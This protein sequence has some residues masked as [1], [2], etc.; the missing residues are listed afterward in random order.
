MEDEYNYDVYEATDVDCSADEFLTPTIIPIQAA[1]RQDSD[2]GAVLVQ[3]KNHSM[4]DG[5]LANEQANLATGDRI[6]KI[7]PRH[8]PT[9]ISWT[10]SDIMDGELREDV[11]SFAR[12]FDTVVVHVQCNPGPFNETW[13][14]F[15]NQIF[16][17][18]DNKVTYVC[19]NWASDTFDT[20]DE[21][22]GYSG[23]YTKAK[24]RSPLDR[25]DTTY[26]NGGLVGT[27]PSYRCDYVW[28]MPNDVVSRIQ[29]K[30]PNPGTT[31]A[32]APS[33][34][35]PRVY[36]TW[37]W[38]SSAS[39]YLEDCPG[40]PECNDTTYNSWL[41]QLPDSHLAR[42]LM[43]AIAL[44]KIDFDRLPKEELVPD[45]AFD[46]AALETLTDADGAERLG[47]VLS[48]HRRRT[49]PSPS[50]EMERLVHM[51]DKAAELNICMDDEF[52]LKDVPMNAEYEDKDIKVCLTVLDRWGDVSEQKG[53]TRLRNWVK[54]R[55]DMRFKP[56][57]V[58]MD[59][60]SGLVLK[61]LE[62]HEDVSQMNRDP[63]RVS[64][65]GGLVRVDR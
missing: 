24:R 51:L 37:T 14:D 15:R 64:N 57:V 47:H 55:T 34:S 19:A 42:E 23:V 22:F 38:D 58:T 43:A 33:F 53:A 18:S 6:W 36:Q 49:D 60:S 26:E 10:C 39:T 3:Y 50:E 59:R 7:D 4:S 12:E 2:D 30:R 1:A 54:R 21:E 29:F 52:S 13:V 63:E 65:P 27:K 11:E 45:M 31:G 41:S 44:G 62:G 40:V 20:E 5:V 8:A 35:L 32:G 56:L 46:W 25:Y 61:T 28:L 17:G 48:S 16:D 9:V